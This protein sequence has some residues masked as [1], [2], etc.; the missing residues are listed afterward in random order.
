MNKKTKIMATIG[1]ACESEE[2]LRRLIEQGVNVFR[3]NLKHNVFEWHKKIINRAKEIAK[4]MQVEIGVLV[5]FQGPEVRIETNNEVDIGLV[6]GESLFIADE[7]L[8]GKKIIKINPS[9][10]TKKIKVGDVIYLNSGD[11]KLIVIKKN[12]KLIELKSEGEAVVKNRKSMNLISEDLDLPILAKRD[13][14]T[15]ARLEQ[16]NP[17]YI[18]LS[19]VRNQKDIQILKSLLEKINDR[20]KVVAKIENLSAIK[21]IEDIIKISDGIMIARGDLGIEIPIKELAFWQKKIIDLCRKESK[22]VIVATQMLGS[23]VENT[24]PTRA[25][26]TDVSN[27]IFDGT[28]VLMLSEETS[29]GNHPVKV[30]KEMSEIASFCENIEE[31]RNI[32]IETK[33]ATEVLVDA[34]VNII[35]NNK[36]LKIKAVVIFTESG[37]TARIF[38]RYRL[39]L[40]IIAMTDKPGT[41]KGLIMSYGVEPY[42]KKFNETNFRMPKS[43]V[44]N[45][46]NIVSLDSGD[47]LVVIHGNNWMKSESTSDISLVTV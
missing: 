37:K 6:E 16:I 38:S 27:A 15:L 24:Q 22:P 46:S 41:V 42:Y 4:E 40:P 43:L 3:F 31:I 47:T 11:L 23:M 5:D 36:N 10:A 12:N 21:N 44:K 8:V 45:I 29:I 39:N 1:P 17:D 25:E 34:A 32:T 7:F 35:L 33:S 30:V 9:V 20:V 28:D 26:A 2:V 19:F 14:E 18:A 13:M